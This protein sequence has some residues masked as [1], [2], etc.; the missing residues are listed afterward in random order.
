M[1]VIAGDTGGKAFFNTNDINGSIQK[2]IDDSRAMYVLTYSPSHDQWNGKFRQI[3]VKVDR[4]GVQLRYR[5]GYIAS[6]ESE[7][8][9][10]PRKQLIADA[11]RSPLELIDLR[12]GVKAAATK[13]SGDWQ[14]ESQIHVDPGQIQFQQQADQWMDSLDIVWVELS[15]DG[16]VVARGS[17]TLNL[18]SDQK[19]YA[20]VLRNGLTFSEH[21][22]VMNGAVEIRLVIAD[23][24]SGLIG[25]VNVPLKPVISKS[26]GPSELE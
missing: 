5:T 14:M 3:K 16:D 10:Q 6:P 25:S 23:H 17:H 15:A 18:K 11:L 22:K 8:N 19:G 13:S 4:P 7:K 1:V 21:A 20:E 9:T 12:F 2:V 26:E 24:G